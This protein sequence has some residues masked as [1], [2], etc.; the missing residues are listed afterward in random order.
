MKTP[1]APSSSFFFQA[2]NWFGWS[3]YLA[4]SSATV[5]SLRSAPRATF[6][7][8]FGIHPPPL[9]LAHPAR[10]YSLARSRF[11]P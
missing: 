8:Q 1:A 3:W 5:A 4:A 9:L 6:R 10:P 7:L 11:P 2:Q